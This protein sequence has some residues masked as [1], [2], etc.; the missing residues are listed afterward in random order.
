MIHGWL[1][2]SRKGTAWIQPARIYLDEYFGGLTCREDSGGRGNSLTFTS[3]L[4][5]DALASKIRLKKM[6]VE[7]I[8]IHTATEIPMLLLLLMFVVMA[9][10]RD[11]VK[12]KSV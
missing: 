6:W 4:R 11:A 2:W 5:S 10:V 3:F 8:D 7:R 1:G 9:N 12:F